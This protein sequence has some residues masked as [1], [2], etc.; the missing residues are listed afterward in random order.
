M[1]LELHLPKDRFDADEVIAIDSTLMWTGP[2]PKQSVWHGDPGPVV[3][4]LA[5]VDGRLVLGA[6][7]NTVCAST[8]L[9]R[10]VPLAQPYVKSLG[11]SD[12]DPDAALYRAFAAD[13]LLHLSP[14]RWRVTAEVDG[15]LA[16][17]GAVAPP[18]Q[19]RAQAEFDVD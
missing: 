5:Q 1:D 7:V 14:G 12:D 11:W 16:P 4:A 13:P 9:T 18:L 8:E 17:C 6:A 19:L 2:G 10:G 3:Y 15:F